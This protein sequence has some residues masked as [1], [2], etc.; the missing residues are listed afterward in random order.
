MEPLSRV[1]VDG[2]HIEGISLM[3]LRAMG[4]RREHRWASGAAERDRAPGFITDPAN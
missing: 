1:D 2:L 3:D 4:Y